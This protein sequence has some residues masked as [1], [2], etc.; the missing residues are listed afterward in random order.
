MKDLVIFGASTLARLAHYY[1]TSDLHMNVCGFV[2]DDPHK[3]ADHFLS[4]PVYSWSEFPSKFGTADVAVHVAIGY[5]IMRV[6]AAAYNTV[7]NIG[8]ELINIVSKGTYV[9]SDVL[10]G[11]NNF[12]MPGVVLESGASLGANNVVWSNTTIC[13][14]TVIGNHN[15]LA[16]NATVGGGVSIGNGNF[17]GFSSVIMQ[18]RKIG[19]ETLI[20][21]QALVRSDTKDLNQYHGIPALVA[22]AISQDVGITVS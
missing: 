20:G 6:R 21:A 7:K 4:L 13:H 18:G 3:T 19:N 5:R 15:F 9:A 2:V 14:D 22:A 11:D 16:A 8:Y 17:L 12:I 10:L 1:A